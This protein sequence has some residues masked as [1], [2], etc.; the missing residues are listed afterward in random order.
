MKKLNIGID[1]DDTITYTFD[2]LMPFLAEYFN[3]D[4]EYLKE[5]N[6]S[7]TSLPDDIKDREVEFGKI[8]YDD[9]ILKVP[10]REDAIYFINKL[11]E[12]G[13]NI[14]FVTARTTRINKDPIGDSKKYLDGHNIL[15]DDLFCTTDKVSICKEKNID[16][17]ID[18]SINNCTNISNIGIDVLLFDSK[19][20]KHCNDFRRVNNWEDVYNYINKGI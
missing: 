6:I 20:N 2:Y 13:H 18:D 15:Y 12:E 5:N 7:Y 1:I 19:I 16:L 11:K 8:Y 10:V 9:A 17:F 4:L 3:L 14:I